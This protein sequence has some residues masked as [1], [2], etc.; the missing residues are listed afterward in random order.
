MTAFLKIDR[1]SECQRDFPWEWVPTVALAGRP[2]AGTGV[3]RSILI[4]GRCPG[5][6]ECVAGR[7]AQAQAA[8]SRRERFVR[9]VG[10]EE[11]LERCTFARYEATA[12]NRAALEAARGFSPPSSSLYLWGPTGV[13]KTHLAVA[14]LR[15]A[16][17]QGVAVDMVT[18]LQLIRRIRMRPPDEEQRVID[19]LA[20][21]SVLL[22]DDFDQGV[23]TPFARSVLQ[24]ILDARVARR[25]AGLIVTAQASPQ[26][27]ARVPLYRPIAS[28]LLGQCR[29]VAITGADRRLGPITP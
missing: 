8:R 3:W 7:L 9:I 26:A 21:V 20:S 17:A 5:C 10:G 11:V 28:R 22:L 27:L 13:G 12:G 18:P 25:R 16:F 2:L 4:D 24:E 1:C 15:K 19:D 6:V 23:E 14:T 29:V